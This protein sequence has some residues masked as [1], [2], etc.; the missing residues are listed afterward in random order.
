[1][2]EFTS[3]GGYYPVDESCSQ[4]TLHFWEELIVSFLDLKLHV[5]IHTYIHFPILCMYM[6]MY[7]GILLRPLCIYVHI[8]IL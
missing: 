2:Q 6:C 1:M 5:H 7:N 3:L 8:I 4:A